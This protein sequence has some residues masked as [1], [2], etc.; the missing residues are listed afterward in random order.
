MVGCIIT[1]PAKIVK[2]NQWLVKDFNFKNGREKEI[3][4]DLMG[5]QL[6]ETI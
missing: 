6:G 3:D 5:R 4:R 1:D 2:T